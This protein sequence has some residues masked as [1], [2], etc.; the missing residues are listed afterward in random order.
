MKILKID[1]WYGRFGNNIITLLNAA[2][3]GLQND[4]D[5]VYFDGHYLLKTNHIILKHTQGNDEQFV[6]NISAGDVY[7]MKFNQKIEYHITEREVFD[8]YVAGV[9]KEL[10]Q[11]QQPVYDLVFYLRGEDIFRDTIYGYPQPP[12]HFYKQI[13]EMQ[14][15]NKTLMVT[16][17]LWNPVARHM[18]ENN[19]CDWKQQDFET[20][21]NILLHSEA[22]SIA[23]SSLIIFVILASKNLKTL[24]VPSYIDEQFYSTFKYNIKDLLRE[25]QVMIVIDIPN[26]ISTPTHTKEEYEMM[27]SYRPSNQQST[28]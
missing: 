23:F 6:D 27:I 9:I 15:K 17:D 3:Y 22:V 8:K 26:Y 18:Y 24:Y 2:V 13:L 19:I 10:G 1:G 7:F 28:P 4:Y 11:T 25:D 21:L 12:L 16:Q 5:V 14:N 20:D